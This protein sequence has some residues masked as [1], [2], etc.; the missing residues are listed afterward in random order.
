MKTTKFFAAKILSVAALATAFALTP[1][2]A[3]AQAFAVGVQFGQ[4]VYGYNNG[5]DHNRFERERAERIDFERR[6]AFLRQQAW[7]REHRFRNH[8]RFDHDRFDYGYRGR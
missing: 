7:E 6:Q 4:P 2:H 3:K 5:Y 1:M 8:D